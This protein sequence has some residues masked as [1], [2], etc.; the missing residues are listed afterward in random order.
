MMKDP[1]RQPYFLK[2][3]AS[4]KDISKSSDTPNT[5]LH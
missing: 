2:L 1:V 5:S 3:M 4:A